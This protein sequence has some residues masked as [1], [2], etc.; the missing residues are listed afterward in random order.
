MNTY[1]PLI[2]LFHILPHL[3]LMATLLR[4][5]SRYDSPQRK[6]KEIKVQGHYD[7]PKIINLRYGSAF[8]CLNPALP[9]A[10][11]TCKQTPWAAPSWQTAGGSL[12]DYWLTG[13]DWFLFYQQSLLLGEA[14]LYELLL[15]SRDI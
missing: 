14:W 11:P 15:R 8:W 1:A 2:A 6:D 12:R 9:S 7:L 5:L 4:E 13:V 10:G 3:I